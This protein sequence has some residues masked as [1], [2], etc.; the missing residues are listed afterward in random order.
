MLTW[1]TDA[2]HLL[3]GPCIHVSTMEICAQVKLVCFVEGT[4]GLLVQLGQY[5][6]AQNSNLGI[7]GCLS[8]ATFDVEH[9]SSQEVVLVMPVERMCRQAP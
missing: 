1:P 5:V 9:C 3:C 6:A 8:G 2:F 7:D 4:N